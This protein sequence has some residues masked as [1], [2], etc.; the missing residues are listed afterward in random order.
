MLNI[1]KINRNIYSFKI[2]IG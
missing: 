1:D 2:T